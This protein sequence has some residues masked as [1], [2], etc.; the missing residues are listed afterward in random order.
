[1]SD[2]IKDYI[3]EYKAIHDAGKTAG[4]HYTDSV[5]QIKMLKRKGR[6]SEAISILLDSVAAT[7]AESK[8]GGA[9]WGVAP[10]YYEQL[11][12]LF[13]KEKK[14]QDEIA[15]LERYMAQPKAP[16]VGPAKLAKRLQKAKEV[17]AK[18]K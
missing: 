2:V 9:G 16:G 12:I 5:D 4:R 3:A 13:R 7:E 8:R 15:I 6:N 10:W 1:M 11:A 14:I 17:A 18:S